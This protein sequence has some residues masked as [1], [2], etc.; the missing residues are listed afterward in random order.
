MRANPFARKRKAE[1]GFTAQLRQG[2]WWQD[3]LKAVTAPGEAQLYRQAR[4]SLPILDA[5][6]SKLTRLSGGFSA[7]TGNEKAD[8]ELEE[9]L[10]TVDCGRAQRGMDAFLSAYL[11]SLLMYGRAIGEMVVSNEGVQAVLWGDVTRICVLDEGNPLDVKLA[12]LDG[13]EPKV[14]PYQELLLFTTLNPEPAHPYGVSMLRGLP[15]FTGLLERIYRTIGSNW[16]RAGDVR[17]SVICRSDGDG[18]AAARSEAMAAEWAKAMA[19]SPGGQVSD[20]VAVGDVDI[21]VIG[22][23]GPILDSQVPVRQLLEQ[24]VAK[25]GLPPFLLGLSWS[26]TERMSAQQ[27]DLLTSE[28]WALRRTVEPVLERICRQH[29]LRRGFSEP[30]RIEWEEI[31][32]ADTVE[33]SRAALYRAQAKQLEKASERKSDE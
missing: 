9:F 27:A 2:G 19:G 14:L 22:A 12:L 10:R 13:L 29:L 32:L 3:N 5:A 7:K 21:R 18:Q 17:Y 15:Y 25:T 20:F 8:R 4:E 6:I 23:D 24:I 26:T 11:D 31:S 28:L 16:E 1:P 30:V 33:E